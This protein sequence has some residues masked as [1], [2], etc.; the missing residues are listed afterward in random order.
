MWRHHMRGIHREHC[1]EMPECLLEERE[2]WRRLCHRMTRSICIWWTDPVL[3]FSS[4]WFLPLILAFKSI[5][6]L[7]TRCQQTVP[8]Y[9]VQTAL[10]IVARFVFDFADE[11]SVH[12]TYSCLSFLFNS[13]LGSKNGFGF[14]ATVFHFKLFG[15]MRCCRNAINPEDE[16]LN[17]V[18]LAISPSDFFCLH[19]RNMIRYIHTFVSVFPYWRSI[20]GLQFV[21][22]IIMELWCFKLSY[23]CFVSENMGHM[24]DWWT[25]SV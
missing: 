3:N 24:W 12:R 19:V 13:L 4:C 14:L 11:T 5:S 18:S 17:K 1:K 22:R 6:C 16:E 8:E 9:C 10:Q 2:V 21:L 23:L 25:P 20:L 15:L 7:L